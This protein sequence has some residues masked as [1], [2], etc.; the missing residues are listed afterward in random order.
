[1]KL[2]IKTDGM[3]KRKEITNHYVQHAIERVSK[4]VVLYNELRLPLTITISLRP[5]NHKE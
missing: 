4:I 1:M 2:F 3:T 5:D